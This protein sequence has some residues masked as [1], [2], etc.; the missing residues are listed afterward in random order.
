MSQITSTAMAV[1]PPPT[2]SRGVSAVRPQSTA[3]IGDAL[4]SEPVKTPV[5]ASAS[6]LN[7]PTTAR[8]AA[9]LWTAAKASPDKQSTLSKLHHH[10]K[11]GSAFHRVS[12]SVVRAVNAV[13]TDS[14]DSHNRAVARGELRALQDSQQS[15][16]G[17][18]NNHHRHSFTQPLPQ[19]RSVPKT[20]TLPLSQGVFKSIAVKVARSSK[21]DKYSP[22]DWFDDDAAFY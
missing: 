22:N 7:S 5:G 13:S 11:T 10:D 17:G 1:T 12:R 2:V 16:S 15:D 21:Q 20:T 3:S 14:L 9:A 18:N 4:F 6:P 8:V 19:Q